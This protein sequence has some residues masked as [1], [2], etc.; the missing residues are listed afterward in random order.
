MKFS[1]ILLLILIINVNLSTE[2]TFSEALEF[3]NK[4]KQLINALIG[5]SFQY[6]QSRDKWKTVILT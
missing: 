3:V 1:I 5:L 4:I 2:V 6:L